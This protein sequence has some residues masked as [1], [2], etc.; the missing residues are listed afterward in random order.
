MTDF[1]HGHYVSKWSAGERCNQLSKASAEDSNTALS[2][3]ENAAWFVACRSSHQPQT[4]KP[5]SAQTGSAHTSSPPALAYPQHCCPQASCPFSSATGFSSP[6]ATLARLPPLPRLLGRTNKEL[7]DWQENVAPGFLWFTGGPESPLL[8]VHLGKPE[9][10]DWGLPPESQD[11]FTPSHR[12]HP[13]TNTS[14]FS[15]KEVC[16]QPQ[17]LESIAKCFREVKRKLSGDKENK[18]KTCW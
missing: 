5:C 10:W 14:E 1:K 3:I 15:F 13:K 16:S 7:G 18:Q 8:P 17:A 9:D 11:R 6:S 12:D 4:C 2:T